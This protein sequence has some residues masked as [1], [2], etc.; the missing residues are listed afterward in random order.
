MK[1]SVAENFIEDFMLKHFYIPPVYDPLKAHEY[2][3]RNR[4][5]KGRAVGKKPMVVKRSGSSYSSGIKKHH[6]NKPVSKKKSTDHVKE[7]EARVAHLQARLTSLRKVLAE[8]VKQ[9]KHRSGIETPT[10]N[11]SSKTSSSSSGSG[12]RSS[13]KLTSKQKNDAAKRSKEYYDKHKKNASHESAHS[14]EA[15]IKD[16]EHKISKMRA[17]LASAKSHTKTKKPVPVGVG[18]KHR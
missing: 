11:S 3:L 14:I 4:K 8:L 1:M 9:A 2:Y 7:I 6:V 16:V 12:S 5:L 10:K 18:S 15:K 13:S 17:E